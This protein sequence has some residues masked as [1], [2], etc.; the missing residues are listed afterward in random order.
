MSKTLSLDN[1]TQGEDW[2]NSTPYTK[3]KIEA[4]MDPIGG[5]LRQ[6][7]SIPSP[8]AQLELVNAAFANLAQRVDL[9]G[10]MIEFRLV[11]NCLDIGEIVFNFDRFANRLRIISWNKDKQLEI[12]KRSNN[13]SHR[14]LGE[15]LELFLAQDADANNFRDFNEFYFIE[16]DHRI[17]GGTSPTTLFIASPNDQSWINVRMPNNDNLF[18]E[19]YRHLYER[20]EEFQIYM[21]TLSKTMPG[22]REKFKNVNDY[23]ER[24]L[25]ILERR[26][27]ALF[28][29]IYDLQSKKWYNSTN[30]DELYV[31]GD[32][33]NK[34]HV[35]SFPLYKRKVSKSDTID[36]DF[37]IRSIK[38]TNTRKPLVLIDGH[39]GES[40]SGNPMIYITHPYQRNIKVP[41]WYDEK[42]AIG[43]RELPG[44]IGL[45]YPF[46]LI[47][48]FL[49]P[50]LIRLV[51]PIQKKKYFNGNLLKY[52]KDINGQETEKDYLLP[53]KKTFFEYFDTDFLT[54]MIEGQKVFEMELLSEGAVKVNLRIPIK[55]D[56]I[57]FERIYYP[58]GD[59]EIQ[60]NYNLDMN[61]GA[62]IE[63]Q[64]NIII[65]PFHGSINPLLA[66][67]Y[68]VMLVDCDRLH[69]LSL[70]EY[71]LNFIK[72]DN[73]YDIIQVK[74][75]VR[76]HK[77]EGATATTQIYIV[78][79]DFD[80]I[81]VNSALGNG[82]I[83]PLWPKT[84]EDS[85]EF[86]FAIDVGTTTTHIEYIKDGLK[87]P[88]PFE[89]TDEDLQ[90]GTLLELKS[91]RDDKIA[92]FALME[93]PSLFFPEFIG[94][95]Y[96]H[97][98]PRRTSLAETVSISFLAP[99]FTLADFNIP[100]V[101]EKRAIPEFTKISTN[102][103][104]SN[105][106]LNLEAERR[107][108]AF[109]EQLLFMMRAKVLMNN[110]NLEKTTLIWFYPLSMSMKRIDILDNMI[111]KLFKIYFT[112]ENSP[113]RLPE[114]V[115]P[116]YWYKATN[117]MT[118]VKPIISIDIGGGS[119]D[120]VVSQN[121]H[122]ELLTSFRFA[123]NALF[124]DS[125]G[126]LA[127]KTNGFV[128]RYENRLKEVLEINKLDGLLA[129]YK[130]IRE[131]ENLEDIIAFFFSIESNK[132][133]NELDKYAPI[134]FTSLLER[135]DDMRI[136]FLVFYGAII[137]HIAQLMVAKNIG[138]PRYITFS[139]NGSKL[140]NFITGKR[141]TLE[142]FTSII[143]EKVY[144]KPY[145]IDGMNIVRETK[146]PK[147][148][149]CKGGL[150]LNEQ[151]DFES[152]NENKTILV[153]AGD[154]RISNRKNSVTYKEL[155][156]KVHDEVE[157][158]VKGFID[159]F[160]DLH[161]SINFM[162]H[163]GIPVQHLAFYKKELKRDIQANL[164]ERLQL[165]LKEQKDLERMLDE[166]L[167]FYPLIGSLNHLALEIATEYPLQGTNN[168]ARV[169]LGD[170][171]PLNQQGNVKD[172]LK[173]RELVISKEIPIEGELN[174]KME[175][176]FIERR[177][178]PETFK[179]DKIFISYSHK[180]KGWLSKVQ[181]NLKVLKQ[182]GL[183]IDAWDDTQIK[184]GMEWRKEIENAIASAK[185]A[186][187]LVS[188]DFL[189]SDFIANNELPPL[190]AAAKANGSVIIAVILRPCFYDINDN[191]KEIQSVNPPNRPLTQMGKSEQE[192]Y[193][194]ALTKQVAAAM[195]I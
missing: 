55:S 82:I 160:F 97:N 35:L 114:S 100:F 137:Y 181:T 148:V 94:T 117:I 163:F 39:V 98:F 5:N 115:A 61:K 186:I 12:L 31:N 179:R 105:F 145:D 96:E 8:F 37:V 165:H 168:L 44:L 107:V 33:S 40:Q 7:T 154:G 122:L 15:T 130:G 140:L 108:S 171:N 141:K 9:N 174:S 67:H 104:W 177:K 136:V 20:E 47:N 42:I 176:L 152:I 103:K 21:Y 14:I 72:D 41:H 51:Y 183:T 158:E 180:D 167:F 157:Q 80:F 30:Y 27:Y 10:S 129:A 178:T 57:T 75:K 16:F 59:N 88:Q 65:Y 175:N 134:T 149:T 64:I 93:I 189:A 85:K 36:S 119:T 43:E 23:L 32:Y 192:R 19:N 190:L 182:A 128:I 153:G 54:G 11:S 132:K 120:V 71:D 142:E 110:G 4:I 162:D 45:K 147:Q 90:V 49:E 78:E 169:E 95:R 70:N 26:N 133:I 6:V 18:D 188:T 66:R 155:D 48:D 50:C 151:V 87:E 38:Y 60:P 1:L 17:I 195:K 185:V 68:R 86:R 164:I 77:R 161:T 191:L 146:M 113:L 56:V 52:A 3:R 28:N 127:T 166:T 131:N 170:E 53:L 81:Q 118:L 83:L 29:R 76:G 106:V 116:F 74:K 173:E 138:M 92:S 13:M 69:S 91:N 111:N 187:L 109:Y 112:D 184:P 25:K 89:I 101:Y 2:F 99:T 143:I 144:Q 125:S 84:I 150:M 24:N 102:L 194:V 79:Q 58:S 159:F 46:L 63:H 126:I 124:G 62:I 139:G 121:N 123:A 193:L 135:D 34:V 172:A 156:K 73:I 22:F